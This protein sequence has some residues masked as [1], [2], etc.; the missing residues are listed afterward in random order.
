MV[1]ERPPTV[2]PSPS[3]SASLPPREI[4]GRD[5]RDL[6][7]AVVEGAVAAEALAKELRRSPDRSKH[8]AEIAERLRAV[9]GRAT[10]RNALAEDGA[11]PML[12]MMPARVQSSLVGPVPAQ[13]PPPLPPPLPALPAPIVIATAASVSAPPPA[14]DGPGGDALRTAPA[15]TL[16]E[17]S[18]IVASASQGVEI[19]TRL[20]RLE[21]ALGASIERMEAAVGATV[22]QAIEHAAAGERVVVSTPSEAIALAQR[23][24]DRLASVGGLVVRIESS[25]ALRS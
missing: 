4:S 24:T 14:T 3:S 17:L 23:L 11:T 18:A 10:I 12:A 15:A 21:H 6:A 19:A 22:T 1:V 20:A 5:V 25:N 2:A 13:M 7:L 16:E 9:V 8:F